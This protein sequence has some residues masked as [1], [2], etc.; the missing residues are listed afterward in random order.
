[1]GGEELVKQ[2]I[3]ERKKKKTPNHHGGLVTSIRQL[4]GFIMV[5][6]AEDGI[7]MEGFLVSNQ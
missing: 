1:M 6:T 5:T 3:N 2:A 7:H 4:Y